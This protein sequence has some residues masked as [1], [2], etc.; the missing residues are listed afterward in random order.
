[1][2]VRLSDEQRQLADLAGRLAID[3]TVASW[4]AVA[5]AGLLGLRLPEAVG[6]SGGSCVDAALV[7][8][9]WG[10]RMARFPLLG[11]WWAAE[12]LAVAGVDDDITR[13]VAS[14]TLRVAPALD[15]TLSWLATPGQSDADP[16][17]V[18]WDSAGAAF[19]VGLD[20]GKVTFVDPGDDLGTAVDV[21]RTVRT[22]RRP[23]AGEPVAGA[24]VVDRRTAA[25]VLA[26]ALVTLSADLLGVMEGALV[27]AVEHS[28]VRRQF[29]VP[30]GSFQAVQH[31]AAEAHVSVEATRSAVWFAAWAV[32]ELPGPE[33]LL[34]A[35]TAKAFASSSGL[36][37]T[38]TAMQMLGGLSQA[39]EGTA[40]LRTRRVLSDRELLGTEQVQYALISADRLRA[41]NE[42]G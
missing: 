41:P 39:W 34:A 10:R 3:V 26:F 17:S 32:D 6:G 15:A 12:L 27:E 29:G 40:H 25:R 7:A 19:G 16:L 30:V 5:D 42:D 22:V 20:D 37:V 4:L 18:V 28:R 23:S 11:T 33:A 9:Q 2:D 8:E 38:E 14:G 35:R 36:E 24:R 13:A 1:M 31:L 21:T